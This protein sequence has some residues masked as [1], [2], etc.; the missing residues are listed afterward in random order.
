M[1]NKQLR[2]FE[3]FETYPEK[4]CFVIKDHEV[5]F[6]SEKR[7]VRPL[8]DYMVFHPEKTD[9]T[10]VDKIMGKG[11]VFLAIAA[12]ATEI[13]TPTISS[14]ALE[15]ARRND[16]ETEYLKEVPKIKNRTGDGFCPI[17]TAVL[18]EWDVEIALDKIKLKLNELTG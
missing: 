14:S 18:D 15:L 16:L 3:L 11:A 1:L 7:G 9:I 6:T 10:V 8:L 5:I 12:G 2:L 17:E 4:T 13:I